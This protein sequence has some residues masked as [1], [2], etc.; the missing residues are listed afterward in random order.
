MHD[1]KEAYQNYW[2]ERNKQR[3]LQCHNSL[4]KSLSSDI[5][6]LSLGTVKC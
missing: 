5:F 4:I 2:L 1:C 6:V 3:Q